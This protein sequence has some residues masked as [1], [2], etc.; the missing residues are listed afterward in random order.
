MEPC[1]CHE[2]GQPPPDRNQLEL[3][4]SQRQAM[5][6]F[7]ESKHLFC[8][9]PLE[10][11]TRNHVDLFLSYLKNILFWTAT[12]FFDRNFREQFQ[13]SPDERVIAIHG[14]DFDPRLVGHKDEACSN[15]D[16]HFFYLM[17]NET[18]RPNHRLIICQFKTEN[19]V[20]CCKVFTDLYKFYDHL[21]SHVKERPYECIVCRKSFTQHGN[22]KRHVKQ[23]H[24]N[25]DMF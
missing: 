1:E 17:R 18:F 6:T 23:V 2:V 19:T 24:R 12:D 14:R 5:E 10:E 25:L 15:K 21:R 22:L 13:L 8:S 20:S 16:F 9:V 4:E 3:V 11:V 7:H